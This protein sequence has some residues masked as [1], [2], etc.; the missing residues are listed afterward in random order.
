MVGRNLEQG[1]KI[2]VKVKVGIKRRTTLT[3]NEAL[4]MGPG[5]SSLPVAP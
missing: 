1:V 2:R 3:D 4:P 5:K